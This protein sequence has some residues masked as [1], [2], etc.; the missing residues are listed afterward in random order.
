MLKHPALKK[1]VA[2]LNAIQNMGSSGILQKISGGKHSIDVETLSRYFRD[3][4]DDETAALVSQLSSSELYDNI[5]KHFN[6]YSSNAV[7]QGFYG[8]KGT[9][10][11]KMLNGG[12]Q[13]L[14]KKAKA[15]GRGSKR[16]GLSE[17]D[18][19]FQEGI[20][21]GNVSDINDAFEDGFTKTR[22][23]YFINNIIKYEGED[24]YK[25][26]LLKNGFKNK[27]ELI[28]AIINNKFGL[29][30]VE[31][32]KKLK[33]DS[34][35]SFHEITRFHHA[36][37]IGDLV[38]SYLIEN[39]NIKYTKMIK[40][41]FDIP[42]STSIGDLGVIKRN[43]RNA[44]KD[45]KNIRTKIEKMKDID[46]ELKNGMLKALDEPLEKAMV[47]HHLDPNVV[48][49][50][51]DINAGELFSTNGNVTAYKSLET[52]K[53]LGTEIAATLELLKNGA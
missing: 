27:D 22:A 50:R 39:P 4:G 19:K 29:T 12:A 6:K 36:N 8:D 20:Y 37:N 16:K 5:S 38:S 14:M 31:L 52:Q 47:D 40:E 26:I 3:R 28:D 30:P 43:I 44:L 48:F 46:L 2:N 21:V 45:D 42:E 11:T 49:S 10:F 1:L 13:D 9:H 15:F 35:G 17:F 24:K 34:G 53:A 33:K 51:D 41:L 7:L 32:V 18:N 25:N 23:E